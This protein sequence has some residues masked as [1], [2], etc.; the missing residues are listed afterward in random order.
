[1]SLTINLDPP[2]LDTLTR[3]ADDLGVPVSQ[4]A[5]DILRRHLTPPATDVADDAT[6]Q[7]ALAA[8]LTKHDELLRRLAR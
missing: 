5:T 8:T 3:Q 6:F 4:L 7:A 1:M 2:A